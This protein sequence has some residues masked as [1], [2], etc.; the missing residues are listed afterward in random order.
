MKTTIKLLF[1]SF[2]IFLLLNKI[3]LA[4]NCCGEGSAFI[5]DA[6]KGMRYS[7]NGF[8]LPVRGETRV[9]VVFVELN[10]ING[11]DPTPPSGNPGWLAHSLPIWKDSIFNVH[12]ATEGSGML[13]KYF[14]EASSGEYSLLGDYLLA[15]DNGGVFTYNCDTSGIRNYELLLQTIHE[16][17][18]S[19]IVTG[20]GFSSINDFDKWFLNGIGLPAS[21]PG[22]TRKWDHV[23]I[24]SE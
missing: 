23:M 17:L 24:I 16:K 2:F 5:N 14:R 18:G 3:S 8:H 7:K 1:L 12:S 10:Y 21:P 11:K 13:T 9:L 19:N 15:P 22:Q 20:S 6:S 4:Q